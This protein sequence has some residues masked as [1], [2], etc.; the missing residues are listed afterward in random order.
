MTTLDTVFAALAHPARRDLV[1][2][3]ANRTEAA[4]MN[5]VAARHRMSP[6]LLNKHVSALE[7]AGVVSRVLR[8]RERHLVLHADALDAA[9]QWLQETRAFWEQQFDA[10]DAYVGQL[11]DGTVLD[12]DHGTGTT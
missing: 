3:L 6:Q 7:K 11:N 2:D 10:L 8:G 4:P 12:S 1:H 9:Q 5:V